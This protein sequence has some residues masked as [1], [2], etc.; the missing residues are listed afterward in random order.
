[1]TVR[2]DWPGVISKRFKSYRG[3]NNMRQVIT[4]SPLLLIARPYFRGKECFVN[5][6]NAASR[7][8]RV[9]VE[10]SQRSKQVISRRRYKPTKGFFS[11]I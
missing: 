1:M 2:V 4:I 8:C 3:Q 11:G 9:A 10:R 5:N 7:K 6:E